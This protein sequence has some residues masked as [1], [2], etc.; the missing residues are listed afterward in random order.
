MFKRKS[1]SFVALY[2]VFLLLLGACLDDSSSNAKNDDLNDEA[3]LSSSIGSLSSSF[4][5]GLSSSSLSEL[6]KNTADLEPMSS[7]IGSLSS[8]FNEGLSSS[9]L[10]E[11]EK[12]TADLEPIEDGVIHIVGNN[13]GYIYD[14]NLWR[15][16]TVNELTVGLGCVESTDRKYIS[17]R[18]VD[19]VCFWTEKIGW[20]KASV[21]DIPKENYFNDE[22]EYGSVADERDGHIYRTI[23]IN[24]MTWMAENLV[25]VPAATECKDSLSIGCAYRWDDALGIA[26]GDS[27]K[28]FYQGICMDGWHIPDTTEWGVVLGSHRTVDLYSKIGWQTGKNATGFSIVP[29]LNPD[30]INYQKDAY[31]AMFVTMNN[32]LES[33][34]KSDKYDSIFLTQYF[35]QFQD[36]RFVVERMSREWSDYSDD[37]AA[38]RCVKDSE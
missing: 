17:V 21:F 18:D 16:A 37:L 4:N 22:I 26:K 27:I 20:K 32:N 12:N 1:Y 38:V 6:E 31:Y 36:G 25:Y 15:Y 3:D 2:F 13:V 10:S 33:V 5:E 19:Y 28:D 14:G 29:S 7:F 30:Y 35:V 11:L 8:S 34:N 24:D 9:S 23:D